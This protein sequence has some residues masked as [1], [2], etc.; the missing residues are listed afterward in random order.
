MD[1]EELEQQIRRVQD[2]LQALIRQRDT[3]LK[4]NRQLR[5]ELEQ[6]HQSNGQHAGQVQ[7]LQQQVEILKAQKGEM[8]AEEKSLL[9]KKLGQYI[10]E[11]DRCIA[12][13]TE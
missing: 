6:L 10:R 5:T 1:L 8:S 7:Q 13:L 11:I 3:L 2:K 4:E 9:D 12:L